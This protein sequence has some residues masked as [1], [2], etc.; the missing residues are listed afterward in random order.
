MEAVESITPEII[1]RGQLAGLKAMA[2]TALNI[3]AKSNL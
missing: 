3:F 2:L 1:E